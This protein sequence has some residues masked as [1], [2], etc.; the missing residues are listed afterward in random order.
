[1]L[2]HLNEKQIQRL[3]TRYYEGEKTTLLI[4]EYEINARPNELY[5][6]FPPQQEKTICFYC[7]VPLIT[8]W[9]SRS[10]YLKTASKCPNCGHQDK[11]DCNCNNCAKRRSLTKLQQEQ[12][13]RDKIN[14]YYKLDRQ[15]PKLLGE[16]SL[17]DQVYLAALLRAGVDENLSIILPV[18]SY[19]DQ[20]SPTLDLTKEIVLSL[21]NKNIICVHPKSPISAFKDDSDFPNVYYVYKVYYYV[22]V[23]AAIESLMNPTPSSFKQDTE[24]CYAIWRGISL[25]EIKQYLLYRLEKVGFPF[26]I[27]EKTTA[28]LDDLLNHFST[29]Q[30]QSLIYRAVGDATRYFQENKITKQHAANIVISSLQRMGERSVSSNWTINSFKRNYDLPQTAISQV[31]FDRILGIGRDGFELCPNMDLFLEGPSDLEE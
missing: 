26:T 19:L 2:S 5:K 8:V 13:K 18:D 4:N 14:Q 6:L 22:N 31:T 16:I 3:I 23:D 9:Q 30:V 1:M 10:S 15:K 12:E 28:V 20:L 17:R 7:Q 29:G 24:F 25:E 27:G 21:A 11:V